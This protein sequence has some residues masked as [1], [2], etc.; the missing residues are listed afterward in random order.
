M[1]EDVGWRLKPTLHMDSAAA[2]AVSGR[3]GLG[4]TRHIEVR[5]LWVA[6]AVRRRRLEIKKARG[7][8]NP[9]GLLTRPKHLRDINILL[10]PASVT[11]ERCDGGTGDASAEAGES[12]IAHT[13]WTLSF[14]CMH[15]THMWRVC[16]CVCAMIHQRPALK[17][18]PLLATARSPFAAFSKAWGSSL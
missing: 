14:P 1:L 12:V 11:L 13:M 16:L 3:V 6:Q 10:E 18:A 8:Q 17:L 2:K 7:D 15:H 5:N 9:A 4:K